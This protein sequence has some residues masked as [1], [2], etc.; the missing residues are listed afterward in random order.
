M[1][2]AHWHPSASFPARRISYSTLPPP[3]E[4][5]PTPATPRRPATADETP[6]SAARTMA[7][8]ERAGWSAATTFARGTAPGRNRRV[9]DSL[10]VRLHW[11]GYRAVAVWEDGKFAV[12]YLWRLIDAPRRVGHRELLAAVGQLSTARTTIHHTEENPDAWNGTA[13]V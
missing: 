12:A 2:A 13:N 6:S 4:P 3:P 9:L 7:M 5:H 1:T 10:A 11:R 8:A